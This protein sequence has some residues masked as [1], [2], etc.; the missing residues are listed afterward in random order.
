MRATKEAKVKIRKL[1]HIA[2][3]CRDAEET[4]KFYE[5]ILG[6]PLVHVIQLDKVPSTGDPGP[7]A[8]LFFEMDDGSYIAFF[9]LGDGNAG[10]ADPTTPPWLNHLAV[11]VPNRNEL[12]RYKELLVKSG[13]EVVGPTDHEFVESIYFFDPNGIRLEITRRTVPDSHLEDYANNAHAALR[14]W[15]ERDNQPA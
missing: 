5:D 8:H 12:N 14:K 4:R 6:L 1:H 9:D 7:F 2:Y 13:V 10:V 3:R 11:E 15:M